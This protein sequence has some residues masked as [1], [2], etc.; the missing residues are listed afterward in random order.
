MLRASSEMAVAISVASV[1]DK[2]SSSAMTRPFSR[3]TTRSLSDATGTRTSVLDSEAT[4]APLFGPPLSVQV[5]ETFLQ[6]KRC[7]HVL[8][9]DPEFNHGK[10]HLGL[11]PHNHGF[12][13]AQ[14][15]HVRKIPKGPGCERIEHIQ[16]SN[17]NDHAA[18]A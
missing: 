9:L 18:R 4:L 16:R 2:P 6:V 5:S 17:V 8:Q 13:T 3:A 10:S 11:D 14:S 1:G 12:G 15:D 7:S